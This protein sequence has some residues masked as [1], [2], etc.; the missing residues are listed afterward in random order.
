MSFVKVHITFGVGG[1]HG[2]CCIYSTL[3]LEHTSS[4]RWYVTE[5]VG[6]YILKSLQKEARLAY[7]P[8]FD[9][10]CLKKVPEVELLSQSVHTRLYFSRC[11]QV[12]PQK[13]CTKSLHLMRERIISLYDPQ[14]SVFLFFKRTKKEKVN[15]L[16]S[17]K[18]TRQGT[19][20]FM[21]RIVT[22]NYI[23]ILSMENLCYMLFGYVWGGNQQHKR[24]RL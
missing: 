16:F 9:D 2:L 23:Y 14:F 13:G 21:T 15:F 5:R 24:E 8:Q 20:K 10:P 7:E 3:P 11:Y 17:P 19:D 12:T 6:G 18:V 22:L 4:H 1:P